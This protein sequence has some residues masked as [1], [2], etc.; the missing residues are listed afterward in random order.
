[1]RGRT[2]FFRIS[3]IAGQATALCPSV[4]ESANSSSRAGKPAEGPG[5]L[6]TSSAYAQPEG[7]RRPRQLSLSEPPKPRRE[8]TARQV[9]ASCLSLSGHRALFWQAEW[10]LLMERYAQLKVRAG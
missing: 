10:T 9:S 4:S 7:P 3:S 1:M 2:G 5:S 8:Y 6:S